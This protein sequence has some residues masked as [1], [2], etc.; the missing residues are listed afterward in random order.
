M[1]VIRSLRFL[2]SICIL[3][4]GTLLSGDLRAQSKDEE[5]QAVQAA[6]Q[7]QEYVFT[8]QT[9]TGQRGRSIQLSGG[10][11]TIKVS[12]ELFECDLPFYG[13]SFSGSAGYGNMGESGVV[14]KSSK[15]SYEMKPRKKGGW[16]VTVKPEEKKDIV[17]I[18]LTIGPDGYTT[19]NATLTNRSPMRYY[20]LVAAPRVE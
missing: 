17:N 3:S 13:S 12:K 19:V 4:T 11:Y 9:A 8:A 15:F 7:N 10:P 20:G 5:R 6:V 14:C 1:R 18:T 2:I 16:E